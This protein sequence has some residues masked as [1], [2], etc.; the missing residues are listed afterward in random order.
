MYAQPILVCL[1]PHHCF[2][3]VLDNPSSLNAHSQYWL[4]GNSCFM[5]GREREREKKRMRRKACLVG[6]GHCIKSSPVWPDCSSIIFLIFLLPSPQPGWQ[7][8]HRERGVAGLPQGSAGTGQEGEG[9]KLFFFFTFFLG[10]KWRDFASCGRNMRR[11]GNSIR[12]G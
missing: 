12:S 1:E 7:R 2:D 10:K 4:G 6:Q 8:D 5:C 11:P 3:T 9:G